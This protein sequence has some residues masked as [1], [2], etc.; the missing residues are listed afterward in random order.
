[1][2]V[3]RN[4]IIISDI[5]NWMD[6]KQLL[7][8]TK[9]QRSKGLWPPNARSYFIDTI[10]NGFPFPKITIR[11]TV[12]L[13]TRKSIREIID[14]QQRLTTINDFIHD[15][16]KLTKVSDK[17]VGC[18]FSD[19]DDEL[20]KEFLSY[21][22]SVDTVIA[23]T[24][25]EVLEIFRRINSY[26]LPLNEAE[27]RHATFQ[28]EFKWFILK[29]INLYSPLFE[30]YNILN[31]RQL[32]RMEDTELIAELCQIIDTG[33]ITR[34]KSKIDDL[35]KKYNIKFDNQAELLKKL[36]DTIDFIKVNL[37]T[38]CDARVLKMYS[39]Y[40]LFS[41]LIYN[42][43]GLQ[44]INP[45]E[46]D[47][48]EPTGEYALNSDI[49]TQNILELFNAVD[50][51]DINGRYRQFV[52]ANKRATGNKESRIIRHKWIVAALQNKMDELS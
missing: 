35:Y 8:N 16:I 39:F 10:L 22:I 6:E 49:A 52:R 21:E 19:L 23:G 40:S 14:G 9:Y 32:S 12:D 27:K 4:V 51:D 31:T 43:W 17:F 45:N 44:N 36:S 34:S 37:N 41:A 48:L 1:M 24:E 25:D 42:K 20:K 29:I 13:R 50:I 33:I 18:N 46:I 15:R 38:I 30:A 11:Q 5:S 47:G 28:G 3:T 7:I 2:Q 26:T